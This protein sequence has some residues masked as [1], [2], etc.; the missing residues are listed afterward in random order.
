MIYYLLSLY[1]RFRGRKCFN[2]GELIDIINIVISSKR[3]SR[4]IIRHLIR[5]GLLERVKPLIYCVKDLD[6]VFRQVLITYIAGRLRRIG[7][8]CSVENGMIVISRE[9]CDK[10]K[11][12]VDMGLAICK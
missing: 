9:D 11:P 7:I 8:E 10:I 1:S 12:L 6:E 3:I 2:E 4:N 5:Q